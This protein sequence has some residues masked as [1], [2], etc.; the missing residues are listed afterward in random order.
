MPRSHS[1]AAVIQSLPAASEVARGPS[2][3]LSA[4]PIAM[5]RRSLSEGRLFPREPVG[6][7][8]GIGR[9]VA[10]SVSRA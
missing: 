2:K 4:S 3:A 1:M 6:C 5:S 10:V 7:Y 9:D 8:Q